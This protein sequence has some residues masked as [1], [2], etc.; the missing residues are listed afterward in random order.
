VKKKAQATAWSLAQGYKLCPIHP[1]A[2]RDAEAVRAEPSRF[3]LELAWDGLRVLAARAGDDVRIVS[4]DFRRWSDAFAPLAVALRRLPLDRVVVEGHI[5]ALDE[6]ARPS[7]PLLR[8]HV[9]DRGGGRLVFALWDL[10]CADGVDLRREPL[11]RR[12]ERLAKLLHGVEAPLLFSDTL[13]GRIDALLPKLGGLGVRGVVARAGDAT[14]AEP[15]LSF[16]SSDEPVAWERSLSPPPAVTNAHKVMYPRDGFTKTDVV[17]YYDAVAATLLPHLAERPVVSQRWPDGIDEFTWYQHRL[18]P[19]APDYLRGE[20]IDGNRRI[21]IDCREALLWMVNQAALTYH[22]WASRLGSLDQPDWALFDLDPGED[23]TWADTI[24]VALALRKLLELLELPSVVKTS[25]QKGLHVLIPLT[26]GHDGELVQTF[27][28]RVAAMIARLM[29]RVVALEPQPEK[30]TGRLYL[31]HLQGFVG[32]ALV[33]PYSLR[34]ADGAPISTPIRW[35]EV[36]PK[37]DPRAF[38]LK[39]LRA[40]VDTHGDLAAPLIAPEGRAALAPILDRLP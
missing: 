10:L 20:W 4:S 8:Q 32:K 35:S 14:Y 25:G 5:C 28:R 39:T 12:R 38:N 15:H 26:P 30:R 17:G 16:S 18:P 34:A 19:Q 37:L 23:T 7:F 24:E 22:G 29:P 33:L 21:V 2:E 31:D 36:T 40:R 27:A 11:T 1:G 13:P 9:A 6:G 3:V